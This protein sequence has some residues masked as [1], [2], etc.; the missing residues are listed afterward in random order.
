MSADEMKRAA[1][2]A[3]LQYVED[4]T[5]IGVGTGST[6]NHFIDLLAD[7]KHRIDGTVASSDASAERLRSV[8]TSSVAA[9]GTSPES[10]TTPAGTGV[11]R[12]ADSSPRRSGWIRRRRGFSRVITFMW[13][14]RCPMS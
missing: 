11:V 12:S 2:Q 1:A 8:D 14:S 3:A 4:D 7:I 13:S 9:K 10:G 5:V 6:A